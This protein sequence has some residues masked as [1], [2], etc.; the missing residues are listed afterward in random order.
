MAQGYGVELYFDPA[1]EN[2]RVG[3]SL[4]V[5]RSVPSLLRSNLDHTLLFPLAL[6][7]IL[8]NWKMS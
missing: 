3:T 7:L 2:Q 5:A 8:Q 1:L 6:P 4:L